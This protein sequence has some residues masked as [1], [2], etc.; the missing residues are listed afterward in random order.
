MTTATKKTRRRRKYDAYLILD[1]A[2][3][4]EDYRVPAMFNAGDIQ[5]HRPHSLVLLRVPKGYR[6]PS[7]YG[8]IEGPTFA[9][10]NKTHREFVAHTAHPREL[11][12][13]ALGHLLDATA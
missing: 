13:V 7:R 12:N 6:V 3:N 9:A 4:W 11:D 2:G 5:D 10:W 1:A 8:V